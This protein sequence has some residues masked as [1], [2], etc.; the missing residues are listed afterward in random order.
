MIPEG[1]CVLVLGTAQDAGVPHAG[2][3]C[4]HCNAA[5]LDRSLVRRPASIAIRSTE[6]RVVLVDATPAI[7]SQLADIHERLRAPRP[8][9]L[10]L[11]HAHMGHYL[12]LAHLG[13]EGLN[14]S[15]LPVY[16][17][18]RM[19]RFLR[20]NRP[21]SHLIKR[22]Q[23]A[24]RELNAGQSLALDDVTIDAIDSPHRG[25]DTD[26]LGFVVRG[27]TRSLAYVPD[28]DAWNDEWLSIIRRMDIALIDGTFYD[29]SELPGRDVRK[30]PHPQVAETV[31][32]LK[33]CTTDIRFVHLNH[34]NLL[35]HANVH[36][37]RALPR[38]F[39]I[40]DEGEWYRI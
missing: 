6:G 21:W 15:S 2:C 25:E 19:H 32:T 34:S 10:L 16:G 38:Q 23:I 7:A 40:C 8:D 1:A 20:E 13:T 3:S 37:R 4:N 27:P 31:Q 22:D 18:T 30:I 17:T 26:T 24:F 9:A 14:V 28:I 39:S 36:A 33:D 5:R 29:D 35:L 12:G 11:T